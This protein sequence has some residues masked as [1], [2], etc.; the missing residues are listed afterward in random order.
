MPSQ[1]KTTI[2]PFT[3]EHSVTDI[4]T[5]WIFYNISPH[6]THGTSDGK[7]G[8]IYGFQVIYHLLDGNN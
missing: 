6:F 4:A 5:T 2:M 1:R 7:D 3:I 8:G